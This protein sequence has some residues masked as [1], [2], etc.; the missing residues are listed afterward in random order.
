MQS[1]LLKILKKNKLRLHQKPLKKFNKSN[2]SLRTGFRRSNTLHLNSLKSKFKL[3][4]NESIQ[5]GY[6]YLLIYELNKNK[7]KIIHKTNNIQLLKT[8]T[9]GKLITRKIPGPSPE[10]K[11]KRVSW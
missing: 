3:K 4:I 1:E 5:K 10:A 8:V 2:M 11:F 6:R 9:K 7:P